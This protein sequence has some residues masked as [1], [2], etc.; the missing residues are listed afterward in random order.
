MMGQI[1]GREESESRQAKVVEEMYK[2]PDTLAFEQLDK[3]KHCETDVGARLVYQHNKTRAEN[4]GFPSVMD[5]GKSDGLSEHEVAAVYGWTTGDYRL[6]N[7]AARGEE[8]V[9]FEDYMDDRTKITCELSFEEIL[10]YIQEINSAMAKLSPLTGKQRIYR[11]HRR[12]VP[13]EVGSI[14]ML[15]GF[16]SFSYDRESALDI[17]KQANQGRSVQRTLLVVEESFTGRSIAKLSARRREAEVLFPVN[18]HFEVIAAPEDGKDAEAVREAAEKL[19]QELPDAEVRIVY[20]KE[21]APPGDAA[22]VSV[23]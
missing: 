21:V 6:I 22:K 8:T 5:V 12:S 1:F 17:V 14:L 10:P 2:T 20:L 4:Q 19:R 13:G 11:G 7:P 23:L 15:K 16:T 3:W 9:K 18:T